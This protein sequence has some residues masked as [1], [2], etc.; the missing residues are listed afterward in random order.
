[1]TRPQTAILHYTAP[2]VVGGVE[3]VIDAH[4]QAFVEAGYPVTVIAGRGD[5]EALPAEAEF[6]RIPKMDSRH[7]EV[8][9]VSSQLRGGEVPPA[10]HELADQLRGT[11]ASA[12][13]R[14][15]NVI[16][17]NVFTKRFNL[18][19]TAALCSWLD[20]GVVGNC[21]AWCHDVGW[22]SDHS[23]PNLH[24]GYPWDLL[25][26][27]HRDVTY[28]AVSRQ[29]QR[30][31]AELFNCSPEEIRVVYN[32]VDPALL[33]GLTDEGYGL[34]DRLDLLGADVVLL[35]PVRVTRAKNIELAL[36]VVAAL[37]AQG[38]SVKLVLTGPPDPHDRESMAYF[39]RLQAT[40]GELGVEDEMRFVFES[41]SDPDAGF[42]VEM[43][44]V[45]DLFR[46]S[47]V[48]FMPS[49]REGFGMPVL[50]AGLVGVPVVCTAVPAAHEIGG[51]DVTVV[52]SKS[53]PARIAQRIVS[54]LEQSPVHRLR[55]RVRQR[56]SWQAIF[57][58][59]IEPLLRGA[60]NTRDVSAGTSLPIESQ[61]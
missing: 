55:R 24:P 31:L 18:P 37:K 19:L 30:A 6:L 15:D 39:R 41:G 26:T 45:A 42:T 5:L 8:A 36:R 28:V 21:V 44:I 25:R 12:L 35:M 1:M 53:D 56:Y 17:H 22:T 54:L 13:R 2:P 7:P 52:D 48:V 23:R 43:P 51:H 59:D 47:D 38:S 20:A 60:A 16:V 32:G 61:A 40:R 33:L 27:H 11:L 9:K 57:H 46:V 50:E 10:F 49:H 29:R 4:V 34:V 58:R 14:F 3:G